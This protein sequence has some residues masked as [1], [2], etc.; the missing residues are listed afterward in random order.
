MTDEVT[1]LRRLRKM[2]L[3]VRALATYLN[4]RRPDA[5][6][7]VDERV[8]QRAALLNWRIARIATGWLRSH[9]YP[10]YQQDQGLLETVLDCSRAY[11]R[12][13]FAHMRRQGMG[14]F[15]DEANAALRALDDARA[16]T[17]SADLSDALGRAQQHMRALI[18]EV[19]GQVAAK[20]GHSVQAHRGGSQD[21]SPY[22]AL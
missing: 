8:Y 14:V 21:S 11:L 9:P 16:L 13:R 12:A 4:I 2:A 5:E 7:S 3:R 6:V 1:R 18:G 17:W 19:R 15:L 10:N 22:L 20:P